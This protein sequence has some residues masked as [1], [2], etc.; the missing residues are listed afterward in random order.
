MKRLLSAILAFY[1]VLTAFAADNN[2]VG[3]NI[4]F[5]GD[6]Y[7]RNHRRPSSETWHAKAAANLG[8]NYVNCGRNGSSIAFDRTK[9]GFGPAMTERYKTEIPDSAD[10]IVIIAGHNDTGFVGNDTEQKAWTEFCQGLD[11][12]LD[13]LSSKFPDARLAFVT[14][15]AVERPGFKEVNARIIEACGLR[16]IPVLDMAALGVIKVNNPEFRARYFQGPNDT[17]HLNA[18]GHDLLVPLGEAFIQ[19]VGIESPKS[20]K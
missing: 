18:E 17:A 13:G 20:Q 9:D 15:W 6:S 7:V 19:L 8:M 3:K 2:L 10:Y 4:V 11:T 1:A 5:L 14:P 12:L 16:G